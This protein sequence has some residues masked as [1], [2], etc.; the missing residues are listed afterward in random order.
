LEIP[1]FNNDP[2][3]KNIKNNKITPDQKRKLIESTQFRREPPKSPPYFNAK[4]LDNN[5]NMTESNSLIKPLC[6]PNNEEIK[7]IMIIAKSTKCIII[8]KNI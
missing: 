8:Y 3:N 4:I 6:I 7:T 1:Q 5:K 2:K